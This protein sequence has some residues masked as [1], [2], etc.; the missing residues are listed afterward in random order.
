MSKTNEARHAN[1]KMHTDTFLLMK[2]TLH[3][4][5]KNEYRDMVFGFPHPVA[6]RWRDEAVE[7]AWHGRAVALVVLHEGEVEA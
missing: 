3:V 6:V 5:K 7:A 4:L 1:L 2:Y